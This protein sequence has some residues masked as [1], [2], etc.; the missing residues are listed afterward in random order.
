MYKMDGKMEKKV[1]PHP[2]FQ[3][4]EMILTVCKQFQIEKNIHPV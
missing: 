2:F 3:N 4:Q 1:L